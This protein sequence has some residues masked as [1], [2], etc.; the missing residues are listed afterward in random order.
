M[1]GGKLKI[2]KLKIN[3]LT[4]SVLEL[5]ISCKSCQSCLKK[6]H[7]KNFSKKMLSVLKNVVFLHRN[8]K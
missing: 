5:V 1:F 3:A 8:F 4:I 2:E 7:I 6:H